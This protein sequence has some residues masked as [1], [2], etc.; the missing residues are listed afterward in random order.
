M[1]ETEKNQGNNILEVTGK[2]LMYGVPILYFLISVAFYLRTY[3]SA[4]IKITLIQMGGTVLLAAWLIKLIEEDASLFF[5]N[6][7]RRTGA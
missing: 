1:S 5:R 2:I 6:A 3:D 4:Q 7:Y